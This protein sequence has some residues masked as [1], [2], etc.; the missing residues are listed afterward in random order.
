MG[1]WPIR[2]FAPSSPEGHDLALF[3]LFYALERYLMIHAW[4]ISD[5]PLLFVRAWNVR[6]IDDRRFSVR[7]VLESI[8]EHWASGRELKTERIVAETRWYRDL[9]EAA[10]SISKLTP[11][12]INSCRAKS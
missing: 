7:D 11:V 5:N 10:S 4:L 12:R 9:Y 8:C 6:P 1:Y 2:A 3:S